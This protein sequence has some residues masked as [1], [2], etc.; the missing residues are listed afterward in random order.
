MAKAILICGKICSGK[1]YYS[2]KIIKN[3]NAVILSC[4]EL[5]SDLFHPNENEYHDTYIDKIKKY[6][7]KKSIEIIN[8]GNSVVLDWGFWT[9]EERQSITQRYKDNNINVEWHYIDVSKEQWDKNIEK[10]N[11]D[12]INNKTTDFYIDEG[13]ITKLNNLF[14]IPDK[15]EIDVWYNT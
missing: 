10:R 12:V 11:S 4:D 9:K 13:L 1:S 5:M 7:I 8:K 3:N 14:E 15:S 2:K 6:L